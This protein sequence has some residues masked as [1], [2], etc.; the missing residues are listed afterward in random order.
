MSYQ[1]VASRI[2]YS[3]PVQLVIMHLKKNQIMMLYWLVLFGFI[4]ESF[5]KRFGIPYL[6]LDPEYLGHVGL[7]SALIMGVC[8]GA[9]IM[10]FNITSFMLN[11]F[12]FPFLAT[13]SKTFIKYAHNNF[14]IPLLFVLV[15]SFCIINFQ[16]YKQFK[17]VG[18]IASFLAVMYTGMF[19]VMLSTLRYFHVTNKDVHKLFGVQ[20]SDTLDAPIEDFKRNTNRKF[21]RVDTYL[22][23]PARIKIVRDTRHYKRYML[24]SVFK[25]N[26][27]N[28]AVVEIVVFVTFLLLGLF[29]NYTF[30]R[31]PAGGSILLLFTMLLMLS[32]VFRYWARAWAN[33]LIVFL[34]IG[35]NLLSHFE[36][37]NPRNQ[38]YGLDYHTKKAIFDRD[39]LEAQVDSAIVKA[40]VDATIAILE[41]WKKK[42][43][44]R[45]VEKP[46][47]IILNISGGGLRS[48]VFAF[49]TLQMVDSV[50]NGDLMNHTRLIC[51]SSGGM[52]SASYYRELYLSHKSRLLHAN[53]SIDN[54]YL[55]NVGK[56]L[57]NNLALSATVA[58][59]FLNPQT[60]KV[61][62]YS[63]VMDRSYAWEKQFNENTF[64]SM[65]KSISDYVQPEAEALIPQMIISPTIINDGRA[66]NISA[67]PTSYL[68]HSPVAS[69]NGF[70]EV[71]N[72]IEFTRFFKDQDAYNLKWTSALRM[73]AS[74]PYIM[75][76]V[77]LPSIPAVEVMDAGIRD[78]FGF[79]N[80][81]QYLYTF[82]DWIINNTSGVILLQ[83]RDTYKKPHIEDNSVKTLFEK[84]TAPMRNLSGNFI[85]MQDYASDR[86]LQ[87]ARGWFKGQLDL[88]C[89]Q[90]PE[91]K[92]RVSLSWHLTETEKLFLTHASWNEDNQQSLQK[93]IRLLPPVT[94]QGSDSLI[95]KPKQQVANKFP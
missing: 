95:N 22:D 10:A 89:F 42:W 7:R 8:L 50:Y 92:E 35:L 86:E 15:Y 83:I 73:N 59:I 68:L 44:D 34:F 93:L 51:G 18:E 19:G 40:D 90:V 26:H 76:A 17:S 91:T 84:M 9:F 39:H 31:I 25:Q 5:A 49:R 61:G 54:R 52:I 20:H 23:F 41:K 36:T 53:M 79:G 72:G 21:W 13:L 71:C 81:L 82:R 80:S 27:I 77:S 64:N 12:R 46:K 2:F 56:D 57:L 33:T 11:G 75:P 70:N 43:N 16:Y 66:L 29:R 78:N 62:K 88:V 1:L 48:C 3:F 47:M 67:Q 30:F 87:F 24:E 74:F 45:G 37:F 38:A 55:K 60:F 28:A 14:I 4:T 94:N 63:Y 6:F 65:N 69:S 58:D 32:G 85:F